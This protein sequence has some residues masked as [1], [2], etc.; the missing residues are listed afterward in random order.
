MHVRTAFESAQFTFYKK[1]ENVQESYIGKVDLL[2]WK[3]GGPSHKFLAPGLRQSPGARNLWEGPLEPE[4][5]TQREGV[6]TDEAGLDIHVECPVGRQPKS[7]VD[8]KWTGVL[9]SDVFRGDQEPD[10]IE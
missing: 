4:I 9:K 5:G 10:R 6:L 3:A 7:Q 1:T 8:P 2:Q